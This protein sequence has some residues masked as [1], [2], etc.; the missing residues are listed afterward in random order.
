MKRYLILLIL[1]FIFSFSFTPIP[2]HALWWMVYHK[3]AFKGKVIDAETKEPIEGAVV[4]VLYDK[5]TI[6]LGAGALSSIINVREVLTDKEG[7]FRISSY[8]TIIQPFS[9]EGEA[10]FIIFKPGYGSFPYWRVS[11]PK[12]LMMYYENWRFIDF[13]EFFSG[14]FG[15]VKEVWG[16]EVWVMGAVP[17]KIK[18]TFGLVELPKLKTREERRKAKPS[19]VEDS[20]HKSSWYYKKQKLLIKAIREEWQ[21]LYG[22]DPGKL[23]RWEDD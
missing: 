2:A 8:T 6:G 14:E 1:I 23:Y 19:P 12:N 13:E 9:V 11:P 16:K 7:M 17:Q 5:A 15:T 22:E 3:P 20:E 21:Y 18:V 10:N 4:V